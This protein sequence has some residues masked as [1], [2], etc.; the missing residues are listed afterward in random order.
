MN[1][2]I[3]VAP[4]Q[5]GAALDEAELDRLLALARLEVD[6]EQRRALAADFEELLGFVAALFE[7]PLDALPGVE[8]TTVPPAQ[9]RADVVTPSLD[10]NAAL[11][12]APKV[13]GGYF[14]VPRTIDES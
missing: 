10:R 8:P 3:P 14:S 7:A 9:G 6:D 5:P 4:G 2:H 11:S 13:R 1:G 12:N